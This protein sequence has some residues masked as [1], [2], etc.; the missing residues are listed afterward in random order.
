MGS[1]SNYA[2]DA[3]LDHVLNTL[4]SPVAQTYVA[5]CTADP[6]DA[7]TGAAMN[8]Y[9]NT[10]DY[11]RQP[12]TFNAAASRKIVQGADIE[13]DPA[14]GAYT[15]NI[16]H[17]AIVDA[18]AHGTGNMLAHGALMSPLTVPNGARPRILTSGQAVEVEFTQI[19][20]RGWSN[21][22]CHSLLDLMFRNQA[23]VSPAG[24]T[25]VTLSST[26]L[27]DD[28]NTTADFT[29]TTW[30]GF[31]R[32]LIDSNGGS[33]PTWDPVSAGASANTHL[34]AFPTVGAGATA[35]VA[36]VLVDALSGAANILMYNNDLVNDQTPSDGDDVQIP[37]GNFTVSID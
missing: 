17:Y 8:E 25:H 24:T 18:L 19:L 26:Q 36:A 31:A 37:V 10:N 34:V 3:L 5:L 11:T 20:D 27:E 30:A 23:F 35:I 13:W 14:N 1:L 28:D 22:L 6:T 29:E 9:P 33:A 32:Q 2:E 16:T 21:Y 12:I 15:S 7:G 4:Y